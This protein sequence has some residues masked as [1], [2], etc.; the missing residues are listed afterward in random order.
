MGVKAGRKVKCAS[1]PD[2]ALRPDFSSHQLDQAGADGE[3]ESGA[4]IL[5]SGG[6]IGLFKRGE[7]QIQFF[8]GHSDAGIANGELQTNPIHVLGK[9]PHRNNYLAVTSELD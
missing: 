8:F 4:T 3:T 2:L 9:G 7:D 1:C 5:A 6:A